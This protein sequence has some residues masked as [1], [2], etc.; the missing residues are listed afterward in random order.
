MTRKIFVFSIIFVVALV[1]VVFIVDHFRDEQNILEPQDDLTQY[2]EFLPGDEGEEDYPMLSDDPP[3]EY[4][5][6]EPIAGDASSPWHRSHFANVRA[7]QPLGADTPHGEISVRHI[8]H[9]NDHFYSR[10]PFSYQEKAAAV[11]LIEELLAIGHPWENIYVQEFNLDSL[12]LDPSIVSRWGLFGAIYRNYDYLRYTYTSQNVILTI[13]GQSQQVIVVGAHYDTL[14]YPGASDN[15]SGTALLLESAQRMMHIDNYYTLVY[16]FFGAEEVGL[17][18]AEYFV[19]SLTPDE[20]DNIL[21][22]VNADVLFEGEYF[23]F[24]GGYATQNAPNERRENDISRQW[25]AMAYEL[26]RNAGLELVNYPDAI[27]LSS[28]Q[29]EFLRAEITVMMLFGAQF[30]DA[31]RWYLRVLHSYRDDYHYI[32]NRW[33]EKIHDAMRTFSIFLEEVLLA[34]Y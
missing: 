13:P 21:F 19:N 17:L 16:I 23:V 12:G 22:M 11:W 9:L 20:L 2:Q 5:S 28:D 15:A 32:M 24:G 14:L 1:S 10:F 26:N 34:R 29:L 25:E 27:F 6:D 33:P 30:D 18:G 4:V 7:P 3:F 31:G 8:R